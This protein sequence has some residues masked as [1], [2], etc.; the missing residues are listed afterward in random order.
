MDQTLNADGLIRCPEC[1]VPLTAGDSWWH[2]P[3][4]AYECPATLGIPDL[5]QQRT[6]VAVEHVNALL[7]AYPHKTLKEMLPLFAPRYLSQDPQLVA[8][9]DAY[10]ESQIE[11]GHGF[12]QMIKQRVRDVHDVGA[13][14]IGLNIGC[15][16]GGCAAVMAADF[17]HV[18]AVDPSLPDLI[19]ARKSFEEQ[20]V[21]NVTLV[22]GF[23]Q[24]LPLADIAVDFAVAENVLEH[25][26]TIDKAFEEVARVLKPDAVF[27]G[28]S[29]NRYDLLR[30]E[31]HVMLRGVGSLPRGL[32]GWY[33]RW[34]RG[35]DDYENTVRLLSFSELRRA[36]RRHFGPRSRV[37]FPKVAY[38]GYP[39]T[40]DSLLCMLEKL[41]VLSKLA[42]MA[43]PAHLAVARRG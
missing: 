11:R 16:I 33:V 38:Y 25:L 20:G 17:D 30:P 21:K 36:L 31:P 18:V 34:R 19:M 41:P 42:L 28:D 15:G 29:H 1:R 24:S 8:R 35:I 12:Y 32:Q 13:A 9:Y 40:L 39:A 43:F 5:R 26:I 7:D 14:G 27:A 10:M 4:C 23:A 3:A 22:Q 2:C 6:I 37:V